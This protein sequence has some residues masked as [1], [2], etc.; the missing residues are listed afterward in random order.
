MA[1]LKITIVVA[2]DKDENVHTHFSVNGAKQHEVKPMLDRAL[3]TLTEEVA[4]YVRCPFHKVDRR[5]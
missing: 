1:E 2:S 5:S 4:S 3:R